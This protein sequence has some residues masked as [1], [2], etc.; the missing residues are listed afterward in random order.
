MIEGFLVG[1]TCIVLLA[2]LAAV[3]VTW[4]DTRRGR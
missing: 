4:I 1:A 3:V 2:A